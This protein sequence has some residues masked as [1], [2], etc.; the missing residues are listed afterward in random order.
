MMEISKPIRI[1]NLFTIMDRG[2]SETMV[3]NLY[4]KIDRNKVQFDF[5]VYHTEKGQYDDEIESLGGK[6]YRLPPLKVRYYL[7]YIKAVKTFFVEHPEYK[8]IHGHMGEIGYFVYKEAYR[9]HV[10]VIILH[11]HSGKSISSKSMSLTFIV[12]TKIKTCVEKLLK[13]LSKPYITDN[14]ACG[15]QAK[16]EFFGKEDR[17]VIILNNA[18]D[19]QAFR[20]NPDEAVEMKK[21]L[22]LYGKYTIGNVARMDNQKNQLFLLEIFRYIHMKDP[23][24]ALI[25]VGDGILKKQI[26]ERVKKYHLED[27]VTLTGVRNNVSEFLQVMDV[28]VFPS[29]LEGVPVAC[30][31]AQA[32]GLPCILSEGIAQETS[33]TKNCQFISLE[34]S[35]EYW[36]EKI[37]QYKYFERKDTSQII[38]DAGYNI[39]QTVPWLQNYYLDKWEHISC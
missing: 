20:Y 8:V 29:L 18:I 11:A 38:I 19:A 37:L 31:E 1:L 21:K 17:K 10:P 33:I 26:I 36:G 32:A 30:I 7:K 34:Q 28:F 16:E 22:G 13:K 4:R 5:M 6:I 27:A 12:K 9:H 39:D 2:G 14:F 23:E 15:A 35:A 25:L 24:T 3:M